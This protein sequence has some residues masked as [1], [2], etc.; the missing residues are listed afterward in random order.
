MSVNIFDMIAESF[1]CC[2]SKQE[3]ERFIL[4][5]KKFANDLNEELNSED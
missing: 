2:R 4:N 3:K 5:L 1:N